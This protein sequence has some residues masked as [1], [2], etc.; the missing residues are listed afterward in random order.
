MVDQSRTY[1]LGGRDRNRANLVHHCIDNHLQLKRARLL[2]SSRGQGLPKIADCLPVVF[3][4][5][6]RADRLCSCHHLV[7]R[8]QGFETPLCRDL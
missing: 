8:D 1:Y 2:V 3:N 7:L 6:E 5:A 4:R